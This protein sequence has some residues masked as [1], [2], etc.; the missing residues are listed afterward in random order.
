MVTPSVH[1]VGMCD[2]CDGM[3]H[4][5]SMERMHAHVSSGSWALQGVEA[6]EHQRPWAYTIG[7]V[8]NFGH[9]ELVII[10]GD[11][12]D[13]A[14]ILNQLSEWVREGDRFVPGMLIE[15][16]GC[17]IEFGT[18]HPSYVRHGLCASWSAYSDWTGADPGRLEL[19]EVITT[20]SRYCEHHEGMPR[21][22][23]VPGGFAISGHAPN[24]MDRRRAAR[25]RR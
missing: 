13:N 18:V 6:G 4:Q 8:Q 23:A 10:D 5:E 21:G 7:L 24:R 22:L 16:D 20:P 11:L 2:I 15:S 9:P 3:T 17:A 1:T 12:Q 25:G 14:I 19:L